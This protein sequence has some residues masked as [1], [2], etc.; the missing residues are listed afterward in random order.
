MELLPI[1]LTIWLAFGVW[2]AVIMHRRGRS[3]TAGLIL[4]A[5]FGVLGLIVALI[6]R[7]R[8][9]PPED[10]TDEGANHDELPD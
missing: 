8:V 9:E 2:G 7:P 4:G 6:I 3:A 10:E 5:M 1:F